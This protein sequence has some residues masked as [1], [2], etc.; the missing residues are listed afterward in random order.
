MGAS[1]D[2]IRKVYEHRFPTYCRTFGRLVGSVT[3]GHD[4]VQ[5]AFARALRYR[6]SFDG[7]SL[8]AWIWGIG[9]RLVADEVGRPTLLPLDGRGGTAPAVAGPDHALAGAIR[10]LPE[11][12]RVMVYLFYYADLSYADIAEACAVEVATVGSALAAA[13]A[14][15]AT[16][17][18]GQE[19]RD[20]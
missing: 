12:Q 19:V 8:E 2:E 20:G 5:E 13:R 18:E 15:L 17:L 9:V 3:V 7:R 6:A 4:I 1:L 11:R 16:A 10:A 14:R